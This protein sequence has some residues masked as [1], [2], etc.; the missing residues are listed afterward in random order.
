MALH[1]IVCVKVVPKPEE[2]RVDPNTRTLDRAK[3]RSE[4]NPPDMNALEAAL[5]LRDE[6]GGR[7]SLISMG[8]PFAEDY[9]R[10]ALAMGADH[11]YLLSDRAF[12]G[13][14]TLA[15][16]YTLAQ[17]IRKIGPFDIILCGEESSDGATAQ[18]PPG[19]AEWLGISQITYAMGLWVAG[20]KLRGQRELRGGHE[21]IEVPLPAVASIKVGINEPRFTDFDR[22]AWAREE[23]RVTVW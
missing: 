5:R 7:V 9:L 13:A 15:T 19:I 4:I 8:P 10:L 1:I 6:H 17:G 3:A 16:S 22:W 18:V 23:G 2:V 20:D 21:V 11:G 14:D 12:G